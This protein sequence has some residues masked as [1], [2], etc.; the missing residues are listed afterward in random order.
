MALRLSQCGINDGV[1]R[2]PGTA[3]GEGRSAGYAVC[4]AEAHAPASSRSSRSDGG[5]AAVAGG[6][7]GL[8]CPLPEYGS[9]YADV[10]TTIGMLTATGK[11]SARVTSFFVRVVRADSTSPVC[12]LCHRCGGRLCPP[13]TLWLSKGR[14]RVCREAPPTLGAVAPA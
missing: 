13:G 1:R 6:K 11:T 4:A 5:F 9:A 2:G 12:G 8:V 3:R 7:E 14:W 10:A